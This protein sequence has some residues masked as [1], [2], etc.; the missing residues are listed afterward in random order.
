MSIIHYWIIIVNCQSLSLSHW[1]IVII[2]HY[3]HQATIISLS[4]RHESESCQWQWVHSDHDQAVNQSKWL[5]MSII[6]QASQPNM[7]CQLGA[8]FQGAAKEDQCHQ[9]GT[10]CRKPLVPRAPL[11]Q[12]DSDSKSLPTKTLTVTDMKLAKTHTYRLTAYSFY[13][14][15][16]FRFG[17]ASEESWSQ[18]NLTKFP[19]SPQPPQPICWK[20]SVSSHIHNWVAR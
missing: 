13:M 1:V 7:L 12:S 9:Y 16:D 17:R 5:S 20:G 15:H 3:H 6:N 19:K 14:L 2:H 4:L 18:K 10:Q 8:H 11:V